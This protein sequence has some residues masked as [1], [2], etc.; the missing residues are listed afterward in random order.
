MY[1]LKFSR[2]DNFKKIFFENYKTK[3]IYY[4]IAFK[5]SKKNVEKEMSSV[6][7]SIIILK[8]DE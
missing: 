6:L 8:N 3:K 7:N 4:K 2:I 5:N 1:T